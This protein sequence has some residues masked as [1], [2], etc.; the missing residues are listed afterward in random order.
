LPATAVT[1][2]DSHE[3]WDEAWEEAWEEEEEEEEEEAA[4][5]G[6]EEESWTLLIA[7]SMYARCSG[8]KDIF[9]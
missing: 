6:E 2:E 1:V 9:I 7:A 5:A 3:E 4:S 8:V